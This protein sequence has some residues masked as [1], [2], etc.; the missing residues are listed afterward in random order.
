MNNKAIT[1]FLRDLSLRRK[2]TLIIMATTVVALVVAYSSFIVYDIHDVKH[3]KV[4][5]LRSLA[6]MVGF[7]CTAALSFDDAKD[8]TKTLAA[9]VAE[10]NIERAIVYRQDY[11]VFAEYV[12]P[13]DDGFQVDFKTLR[14]PCRPGEYTEYKGDLF[15]LNKIVL[16]N[17]CIGYV[18]IDAGLAD[19]NARAEKFILLAL[20]LAAGS[21]I[22]AFLLTSRLQLLISK[23]ILHLAD[24]ARHV[25]ESRDYTARASG[26]SR[27]E[28]GTLV[29][30]FNEMLSEIQTRE[31]ELQ[32]AELE[33]RNRANR[34]SAE[35]AERQ[36]AERE[37]ARMRGFLQNVIDSMPSVMVAVDLE[38]RVQQWNVQAEIMTGLP[39][40]DA[41]SRPLYDVYPQ[42]ASEMDAIRHAI[43]TSKPV[44]RQRVSLHSGSEERFVDIM[45]Y[46]LVTS[47]VE[48]AVIRV[49]DAT[50]RVRLEEMMIQTEKMMSVGG[51]A[52][53]MAHEINNPLGVIMQGV[54]NVV[55]RISPEIRKNVEAAEK[56]GADLGAIRTYLQER[57][58]FEFLAD[59]N[60]AGKRA[61]TIVTNML[62]FS[63][64]TESNSAPTNLGELLKRSVELAASD[65]D[66]K[67]KYDFRRIE[68]VYDLDPDLPDVPCV[69]TK[70]EQVFLNLLK[71]AAQAIGQNGE[72]RTLPRITCRTRQDGAFARIEIEDN[73][74]GMPE[75]VRRRVFEPF[76]TTKE[77]GT[78]T[79]LGLSVS[80]FIITDNHKGR[81][82]VESVSGA[83]AKF[84]VHL[85]L[86]TVIANDYAAQ[87]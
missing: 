11:S 43:K 47:G 15:V 38:G 60:A 63:R 8:A 26:F 59:I 32:E 21:L 75:N 9:L 17:V 83:G 36:R 25:K 14:P 53:G 5:H 71:N 58:I 42:L 61:A 85:P 2:L 52:A 27:D 70:I 29:E 80:Y 82:E 74:P 37:T 46:P 79:G 16:E 41:Q 84:I 55:R 68:I 49:D 51:L 77:V 31:L 78:G 35:L 44:K 65:Y 18:L 24:V 67:K 76:F 1:S 54:Q 81:M 4:Q 40:E 34:L 6:D 30:G 20:L 28:V 45:I 57:G 72:A 22:L 7:N 19:L 48:G 3:T 12:G 13:N 69:E 86:A 87:L 73:G 33:L 56:S 66:L 10:R 50:E 64:R 62:N 23:P 39:R